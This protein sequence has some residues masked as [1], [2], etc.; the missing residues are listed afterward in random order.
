[1]CKKRIWL[2]FGDLMGRGGFDLSVG[3]IGWKG[4]L[5]G[6]VHWMEGCIDWKGALDGRVH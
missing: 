2:R 4:A 6:R 1:M 5:D 3:C